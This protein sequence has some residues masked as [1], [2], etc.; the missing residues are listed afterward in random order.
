MKHKRLQRHGEPDV[1]RVRALRLEQP[2]VEPRA[3]RALWIEKRD[4]RDR[5]LLGT[6]RGR[7]RGQR[8]AGASVITGPRRAGA[9]IRGKLDRGERGLGR[10]VLRLLR[11]GGELRAHGQEGGV[12][13]LLRR[14]LRLVGRVGPAVVRLLDAAV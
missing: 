4:D 2:R 9:T 3:K 11:E 8:N 1:L 14:C 6:E 13:L 7:V 5:G 10:G 12:G